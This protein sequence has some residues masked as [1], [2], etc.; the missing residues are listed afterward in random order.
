MRQAAA[1]GVT[2]ATDNQSQE[3]VYRVRRIVY[4]QFE[5]FKRKII[6]IAVEEGLW[7]IIE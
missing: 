5:P 4:E 1:E 6:D 3:T 2:I 7:E